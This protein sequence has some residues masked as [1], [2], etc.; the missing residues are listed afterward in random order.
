MIPVTLVPREPAV[1][2]CKGLGI[3][4]L[5][6]GVITAGVLIIA[7]VVVYAHIDG[8]LTLGETSQQTVALH[9][10]EFVR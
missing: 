3:V 7:G 1:V 8:R 10:S 6:Y 5:I 2:D 9:S 4:G